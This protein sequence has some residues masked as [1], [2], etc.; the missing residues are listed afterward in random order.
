MNVRHR[1]VAWTAPETGLNIEQAKLQ[2]S[3]DIRDALMAGNAQ[4]M[5]QADSQRDIA[6]A[7][8]SIRRKMPTPAHLRRKA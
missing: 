1:N 7:L 5:R 2:V 8:R 3:M 4:L 6:N